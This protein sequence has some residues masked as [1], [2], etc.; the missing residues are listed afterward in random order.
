MFTKNKNK[1]VSA[2]WVFFFFWKRNLNEF[3]QLQMVDLIAVSFLWE[4][5]SGYEFFI[6]LDCRFD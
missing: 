6:V 2:G 1:T 5:R 4:R 3:T